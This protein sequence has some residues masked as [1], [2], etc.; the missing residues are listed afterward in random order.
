MKPIAYLVAP[1]HPAGGQLVNLGAARKIEC[2]VRLL[3]RLGFRV[4]LINSGHDQLRW[5][6][7][8]RRRR[9]IG[10]Q[11]LVEIRPFTLPIRPLG[12]LA[13]A[14][15]A[16]LLGRRLSRRCSGSL[17]WLYNAYLFEGIFALGYCRPLR[18]VLELEDLPSARPRGVLDPKNRVE[19]LLL[20]RLV[21]MA[22]L[23]SC[24]N[25]SIAARAAGAA[26]QVLL[27]PGVIMDSWL[28][29]EQARPFATTTLRIGYFGGLTIEKGAACLLELLPQMP[30]NWRLVVT[31]SGQLVD[32]FRRA[33]RHDQRLEFHECV[34]D[35]VLRELVWSCD[36]LVNP[37]AS[38]H[39]MND[40]VFPFKVY[41]YLSTARLV[42]S[43][44]LPDAGL[45]LGDSVVTFDGSSGSLREILLHARQ[46]FDERA[47]RIQAVAAEV[48]IEYAESALAQKVRDALSLS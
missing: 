21:P 10:G 11:R 40:G 48:A 25:H 47:A 20:G 15:Y 3:V 29:G 16:W 7:G 26:R 38:I 32:D 18:L 41:E 28:C 4:R 8:A 5:Q 23:V 35:A 6:C 27:L 24:V 44:A 43:T 36:V 42:V 33:G 1:Y 2:V 19:Q 34:S 30:D 37:H 17:V 12:K 45:E 39:A 22:D 46:R 9:L 31:G 14:A 13:N